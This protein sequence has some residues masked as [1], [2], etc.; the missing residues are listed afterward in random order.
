MTEQT[1]TP[2][3]EPPSEQ[4]IQEFER[5]FQ[6]FFENLPER[7][8][9]Q[10]ASLATLAAADDGN[11]QAQQIGANEE[12]EPL[13]EEE[14]REFA[15]RLQSF[16]DSL[17]EGQHQILDAMAAKAAVQVVP[18]HERD[19]VQGNYWLWHRWV[20]YGDTAYRNYLRDYCYRQGGVLYWTAG[21][22]T[23]ATRWSCWR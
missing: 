13:S 15:D 4:D 7:E 17:P 23:T 16:H 9:L 8:K 5:K 12:V 10:A 3:S 19:D 22:Y 21:T 2:P 18:E 20:G 14:V 11:D 1:K 6:E